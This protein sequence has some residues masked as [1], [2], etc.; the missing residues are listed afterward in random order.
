MGKHESPL[1]DHFRTTHPQQELNRTSRE[2]TFKTE[3]TTA[4]PFPM[5]ETQIPVAPTAPSFASLLSSLTSPSSEPLEP[6]DDSGLAD[7][8]A[9][10]SYERAL[11]TQTRTKPAVDHSPAM[12]HAKDRAPK[13]AIIT[14]RL[15]QAECAQLHK[16]AAEAGFTVSAYLRSCVFEVEAL[17]AQVREALSQFRSAASPERKDKRE[18]AHSPKW[19]NRLFSLW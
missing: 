1:E 13:T 5:Q 3:H 14:L 7:D 17:R 6:W 4:Y 16:R 15:T 19:R 8:V 12:R 2:I 18:P 10:I 11:R 9:T